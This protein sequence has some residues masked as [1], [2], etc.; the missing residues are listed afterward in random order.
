MASRL[1]F[2]WPREQD[3]LEKDASVTLG[4]MEFFFDGLTISV[5]KEKQCMVVLTV[6]TLLEY[7]SQQSA[8]KFDWVGEDGGDTLT[9]KKK[10]NTLTI[11]NKVVT[12]EVGFSE[13]KALVVG[14]SK[15]LLERLKRDNPMV[16]LESA[17]I[18]FESALRK[19][20]Y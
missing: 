17:F 16:S 15:K 4:W 19:Y 13:F 2:H 20:T 10:N 5:F 3:L 7:L 8:H 1:E 14:A 11:S 9:L 18:D 6:T 12:V